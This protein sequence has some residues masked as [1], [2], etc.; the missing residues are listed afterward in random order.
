LERLERRGQT[1]K[2]DGTVRVDDE[3]RIVIEKGSK[4][5]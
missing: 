3:N 1:C 4:G 5:I 2:R